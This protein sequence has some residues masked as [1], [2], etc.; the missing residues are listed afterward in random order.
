LNEQVPLSFV[1]EASKTMAYTCPGSV[2]FRSPA[3]AVKICPQCGK[4][5]ELFSTDP[6]TQCGCGFIAFNDIQSCLQWCAHARECAG[7]NVY[8]QFIA[9]KGIP[10]TK[11]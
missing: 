8:E 9:K 11:N 6:Y 5:I 10:E 4:E 2:I 3:L 1:K 7:E